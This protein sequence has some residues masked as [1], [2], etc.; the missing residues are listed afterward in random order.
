MTALT[1]AAILLAGVFVTASFAFALSLPQFTALGISHVGS[2]NLAG[3]SGLAATLP[4]LVMLCLGTLSL[5]YMAAMALIFTSSG[6]A[7]YFFK[8][9]CRFPY[10]KLGN[11]R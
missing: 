8:W 10:K 6:A 5:L 3:T 11:E 2:L 7:R 1:L 9:N 4:S